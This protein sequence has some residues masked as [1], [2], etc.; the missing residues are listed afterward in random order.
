MNKIFASFWKTVLL[1]TLFVGITDLIFAFTM[2]TIRSGQFPSK[3]LVYMGGGALG[4][5]KALSLGF[6]AGVL[7]LIFHFIISFAFTILV[8][9]IFPWLRLQR[10]SLF[11]LFVFSCIHTI[12]VNFWMRYVVLP[13]TLL[14]PQ[15]PLSWASVWPGWLIFAII[16]S[17]PIFWAASKYFRAKQKRDRLV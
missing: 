6:W 9:I 8:F 4:V 17:F 11:W 5:E 16:F 3:M 12:F 1:T 15:K 13:L 2:Q 10:F 14:P 7:G